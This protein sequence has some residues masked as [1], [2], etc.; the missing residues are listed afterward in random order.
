[1]C[2]D[3]CWW[4]TYQPCVGPFP[5]DVI[6]HYYA[7]QASNCLTNDLRACS[8]TEVE[9]VLM[10]RRRKPSVLLFLVQTLFTWPFQIESCMIIRPRYLASSSHLSGWPQKLLL[11]LIRLLFRVTD[12][13]LHLFGGK[14]N[15]TSLH[16]PSHM[17]TCSVRCESPIICRLISLERKHIWNQQK[18]LPFRCH[19]QT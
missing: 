1:M 2:F 18:Q 4:W 3:V 9:L 16:F 6:R 15:N 19:E 7:E 12:R 13:T 5:D 8:S 17:V 14:K 11:N 10:F